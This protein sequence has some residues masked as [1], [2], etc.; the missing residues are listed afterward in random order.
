M[1]F[2][3]WEVGLFNRSCFHSVSCKRSCNKAFTLHFQVKWTMPFFG[4]HFMVLVLCWITVVLLGRSLTEH[5]SCPSICNCSR[6]N[7]N[8]TCRDTGTEIPELPKYVHKLKMYGHFSRITR[9]KLSVLKPNNLTSLALRRCSIKRVDDDAFLDLCDLETLDMSL[10]TLLD[11]RSLQMSTKSIQKQTM[12]SLQFDVMSWDTKDIS[13][14]IFQYLQGR[15]IHH[16]SLYANDI[17]SIPNGAFVGLE[18]LQHLNMDNNLL[19]KCDIGF[20]HLTALTKLQLSSNDIKTC[21]FEN[22]P[23]TIVSFDLPGNDLINIST[24]C[25]QNRISILPNLQSIDLGDNNIKFFYT[26]TF[27]CLPS[28]MDVKL[29]GN[30]IRTVQAPIDNPRLQSLDLSNMKTCIRIIDELAFGLP[31]KVLNLSSSYCPRFVDFVIG[32]GTNIEVLDLSNTNLLGISRISELFLKGL[33]NVKTL[34][35]DNIKWSKI[36]KH[37]FNSMLKLQT[38]SLSGNLLSE[39][40]HRVFAQHSNITAIFL[41]RNQIGHIEKKS[42]TSNMWNNSLIDLSE[43]PF[44]CNCDL[45]WFRDKLKRHSANFKHYPQSYKCA[46]PPERRDLQL[47]KFRLSVADCKEKNP[48]LLIL[49]STGCACLFMFI[50]AVS[51]YKGRWHIRY[52]MYLLRY[53]KSGYKPLNDREFAYDGFVIYS[54]EENDFVHSTLMPKLEDEEGFRLCIH[55][56]NFEPGKIIVDNIVDSMNESRR[57]IVILSKGF[58]Q[59]QWCK[60]ELLIAQDRWL[61]NESNALLLVMLGDLESGDL[62]KDVRALIQTT[63]Y[64]MWTDDR[65]GQQLFWDQ[66]MTTLKRDWGGT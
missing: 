22:I 57:A 64:I 24:F 66:I 41:N 44:D 8:A 11:P 13:I 6:E 54:E 62:T 33:P 2:L 12:T 61:K 36:P 59:S 43:N 16:L 60:F 52:W 26:S 63:T 39:I 40:D 30:Q 56:R 38:L 53:K 49:V 17:I 65:R 37:F 32:I 27:K 25:F 14:G 20:L 18:K 3:Y 35:L 9:R 48:L 31:L 45:L 55:Y 34:H 5:I 28:L 47:S 19:T 29:N 1:F 7:H 46:L 42:F 4:V 10:N 51:I 23:K 58:F 50:S 15:S 21:N